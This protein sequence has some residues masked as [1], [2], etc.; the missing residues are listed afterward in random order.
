MN[1]LGQIQGYAKKICDNMNK[2]YENKNVIRIMIA[3]NGDV[4]DMIP[5][6]KDLK[7]NVKEKITKTVSLS[8]LDIAEAIKSFENDVLG[9]TTSGRDKKLMDNFMDLIQKNS[10]KCIYGEK[11][12]KEA[13]TKNRLETLF[14]DADYKNLE[15]I[16]NLHK[17]TN[18]KCKIEKIRDARLRDFGGLAGI[19]YY[20]DENKF[21][22][23]DDVVDI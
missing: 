11:E 4:K 10:N 14:V 9:V 23:D 17:T 22:N 3:G 1:R 8:K 15:D 21:D 16:M 2:H 6:H 13:L 19:L 5:E 12:I 20:G 7:S 18:Q